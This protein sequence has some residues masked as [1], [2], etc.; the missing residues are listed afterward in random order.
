MRQPHKG[1]LCSCCGAGRCWAPAA[2]SQSSVYTGPRGAAP[3]SRRCPAASRSPNQPTA[4]LRILPGPTAHPLPPFL[5]LP[6]LPLRLGEA[7]GPSRRAHPGFRAA[8][9]LLSGPRPKLETR[10]PSPTPKPEK[11]S[12]V[13]ACSPD[14]GAA[15]RPALPWLPRSRQTASPRPLGPRVGE[16]RGGNE[17]RPRVAMVTLGAPESPAAAG[18]PRPTFRP[19]F[20]PGGLRAHHPGPPRPPPPPSVLL[21]RLR[22]SAQGGKPGVR[23]RL[24]RLTHGSCGAVSVSGGHSLGPASRSLRARGGRHGVCNQVRSGPQRSRWRASN[25]AVPGA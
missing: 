19:Q 20:R 25:W 11:S 4:S 22:P 16:E 18:Q 15:P 3:A 14:L 2:S 13:L 21:A 8:S 9:S 17:G 6:T 1:R 23:S 7:P 24:A 12:P 5:P 10:L